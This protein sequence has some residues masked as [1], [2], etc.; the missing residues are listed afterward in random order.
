MRFNLHITTS[1]NLTI[2]KYFIDFDFTPLY[3]ALKYSNKKESGLFILQVGPV[4]LYVV[5]D[6]ISSAWLDKLIGDVY[7]S[8]KDGK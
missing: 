5:N 7:D 4:N 8:N 3:W 2:G 1:I 6:E